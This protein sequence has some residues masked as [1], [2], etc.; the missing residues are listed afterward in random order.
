MAQTARIE[1]AE[2]HAHDEPRHGS[3]SQETSTKQDFYFGLSGAKARCRYLPL[4][5]Q[6]R[7]TA[8]LLACWSTAGP[9][10]LAASISHANSTES[11]GARETATAPQA[12]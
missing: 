10:A 3:G 5:S 9:P 7:N 12:T 4:C 1:S 2:H 8:A 6:N 11:E